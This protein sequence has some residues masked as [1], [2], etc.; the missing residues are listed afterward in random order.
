MN[1]IQSPSRIFSRK[2]LANS[3]FSVLLCF[4]ALFFAPVF[5]VEHNV[6]SANSQDNP[7]PPQNQ[8]PVA[9]LTTSISMG[10]VP[11]EV[12]L[13]ASGSEDPDGRI[14]Q[15]DWDLDGDGQ[16][17]ITDGDSVIQHTYSEAGKF[18]VSVRVS[19]NLQWTATATVTIT[20]TSEMIVSLINQAVPQLAAV[21]MEVIDT[22][23]R[24]F[25]RFEERYPIFSESCDEYFLASIAGFPSICYSRQDTDGTSSLFFIGAKDRK[26]L[27]WGYPNLVYKS[28]EK[29]ISTPRMLEVQGTPAIAF[30][31]FGADI[32][33]FNFVRALDGKGKTWAQPVTIELI[34]QFRRFNSMTLAIVNGK[35]AVAYLPRNYREWIPDTRTS[36]SVM[37]EQAADQYGKDWSR[38]SLKICDNADVM[39]MSTVNGQPAVA[40]I[41]R[42]FEPETAL[43]G[44]NYLSPRIYYAAASD[45]DGSF[46]WNQPTPV[47]EALAYADEIAF[48]VE[49]RELGGKPAIAWFRSVE[50]SEL[51]NLVPSRPVAPAFA[52][53]TGWQWLGTNAIAHHDLTVIEALAFEVISGTPHL[54]ILKRPDAGYGSGRDS[55]WLQKSSDA[56]GTI[57]QPAV[58]A[59]GK[60]LATDIGTACTEQIMMI[61]ADGHPAILLKSTS[62]ALMYVIEM[63]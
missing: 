45:S 28:K 52:F 13:D 22:S 41:H 55:L 58:L 48:D 8:A 63:K 35:P 42:P 62:G 21:P 36:G 34:P 26:G 7:P 38:A 44:G 59:S 56:Q 57:W 40:F 49:L 15:F 32:R 9:R 25:S 54:A 17:E 39:S 1:L 27:S 31:E 14:E 46:N 50:E 16:F 30:A 10:L 24:E 3:L 12:T 33:S 23:V 20:A 4:L 37:Y 2:T 19:D 61:E 18:I 53:S 29:R 5:L 6:A 51:S 11:L 47:S 43:G 60:V